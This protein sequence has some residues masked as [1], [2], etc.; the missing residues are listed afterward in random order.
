[1]QNELAIY[2]LSENRMG[3]RRDT[4]KM[5][6]LQTERLILRRYELE[7]AVR[8]HILAGE[9]EIIETTLAIPYP[10]LLEHAESWIQQHPKL[11]ENGA[12]YPFAVVMKAG[13]VLIGTMTLRIDK[14]HNKG[15]LA[16]WIG[17]DYWGKG[18]AT[19]AAKRVMDFG[20]FELNLN[21]IWAPAMSKNWAS[22]QVMKKIGMTYEGTLK[23][24]IL[25]WGTY[26]D[27]DIYGILKSDY[28]NRR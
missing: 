2:D 5:Y 13:N 24:D 23:Q 12:A 1:M 11:I 22:T 4:F 8:A 3:D 25:K 21:R 27:V 6:I 19:E 9:K 17:K 7:D 26:E 10:Y 14:Q 15:E 28:T 18:Y 16:Y 20:F